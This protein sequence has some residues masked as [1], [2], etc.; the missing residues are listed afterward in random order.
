MLVR[1]LLLQVKLID[2]MLQGAPGNTDLV[3]RKELVQRNIQVGC[4]PHAYVPMLEHPRADVLLECS[5]GV[6]TCVCGFGFVHSTSVLSR[7][8]PLCVA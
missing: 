1:R 8:P 3:F 7:L 2:A 4:V 5:G 6:G